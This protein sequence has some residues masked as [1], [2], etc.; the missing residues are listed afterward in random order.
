MNDCSSATVAS[1]TK[2]PWRDAHGTVIGTFGLTRDV[3]EMKEAEEKLVEERNLLR[4]I[5]DHLPSRLY[6]KDM[7]SR[8]V[9]NNKSHL[10]MLGATSQADA[11]GKTTLDFFPGERG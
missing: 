7:V 3:T 2:M 4:T 8:Y 6:V 5:I 9:L 1:S 10:E 11:L